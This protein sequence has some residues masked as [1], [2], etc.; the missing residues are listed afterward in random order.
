MLN[1]QILQRVGGYIPYGNLEDYYLWSR[2]IAQ[3]FY[4][5]NVN[6]VLLKMRVGEGMYQR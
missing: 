3:S 5:K 1:K 2:I 6:Y 4:I